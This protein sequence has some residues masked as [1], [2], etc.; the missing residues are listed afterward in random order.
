M[1]LIHGTY[2]VIYFWLA[3]SGIFS[4]INFATHYLEITNIIN[5]EREFISVSREH[6]EGQMSL[7]AVASQSSIA[8]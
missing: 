4:Q 6:C 3:F 2:W 1:F 8:K 5:K 7:F